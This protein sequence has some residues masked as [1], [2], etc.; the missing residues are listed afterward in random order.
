MNDFKLLKEELT[1]GSLAL[2][3]FLIVRA[4]LAYI[5]PDTPLFDLASEMETIL[6]A[7]VK[8]IM[9]IMFAYFVMRVAWPQAYKYLKE[10]IYFNWDTQGE[11][12]KKNFS[13]GLAIAIFFA[14]IMFT[15]CT[16]RAGE[17]ETRTALVKHLE[18]QLDVREATGKNDGAAV[19]KYLKHVGLG[20]GYAWCV[21]F[22]SYNLDYFK[23]PN[24]KSA[25]SPHYAKRK[26]VIW[27]SKMKINGKGS[28]GDVFTIY[29]VNRKRVVHGGFFINYTKSGDYIITIEGNTNVEGSREGIGVFK[30]KRSLRKIYAISNYI[31]PYYE[32]SNYREHCDRIG[33]SHNTLVKL[34]NQADTGLQNSNRQH[35]NNGVSYP[36]RYGNYHP[37]GLNLFDHSITTRFF[38]VDPVA[39]TDQKKQS[40]TT[41]GVNYRWGLRCSVKLRQLAPGVN[42]ERFNHYYTQEPERVEPT[43]NHRNRGGYSLV[44]QR[45]VGIGGTRCYGVNH[46]YSNQNI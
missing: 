14:L 28:P 6:L 24:P 40:G 43:N 16:A 9:I 18:T 3:G 1:L 32:S 36:S 5:W 10:S 37:G 17:P 30:R 25:W 27:S 46:F 21:A 34:S 8:L 31:T 20:E 42:I 22:V 45:S 19:A 13:I 7:P 12:F 29:S 44:G 39:E 26:D 4:V 2:L 38:W 41:N 23:I 11:T 33:S 35:Y 15:S